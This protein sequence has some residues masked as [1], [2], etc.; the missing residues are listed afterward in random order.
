VRRR[1]IWGSIRRN[2]ADI[3]K[4]S[5]AIE[6][7]QKF[8]QDF[9]PVIETLKENVDDMKKGFASQTLMIAQMKKSTDD[10]KDSIKD[11]EKITFEECWDKESDPLGEKYGGFVS[12]TVSG[13]TCQAWA[14]TTPH[15]PNMRIKGVS[16]LPENHCRNPDKSG[17][18]WCYTTDKTKRWELCPVPICATGNAARKDDDEP[19]H[20]H[21]P[22]FL[23]YIPHLWPGGGE[24]GD[25]TEPGIFYDGNDLA[26][27][28]G[29]ETAAACAKQC[30][31]EPQ[32]HGWSHF[33]PAKR[34]YIKSSLTGPMVEFPGTESG[35]KPCNKM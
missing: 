1:S 31:E 2:G 18:P 26:W 13:I 17:G 9:D 22:P 21:D 16:K 33:A 19:E 14:S 27:R 10:M 23:K 12:S 7:T 4:L 8:E 15:K 25:R 24:C 3:R 11:L 32:C 6:E 34:C 30:A 35:P 28:N 20:L 29:V 5:R